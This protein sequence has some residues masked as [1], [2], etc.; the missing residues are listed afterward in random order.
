VATEIDEGFIRRVYVTSAVVWAVGVWVAWRIGGVGAAAGWT[1]GS[2]V[3]FGVLRSFEWIAQRVFV[4]GA[5]DAKRDFVRFS[6]V[7]LPIIALVLMGVVL[8]G[9]RSF[10]LVAA[11]CAG[12]LLTQ[13]VV[14]LKALGML[15]AERLGG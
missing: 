7:K 1:A 5:A 15:V 6:L 9:G 12:V 14:V 11:F 8:I 10:A 2:A 3:S 13:A 4:P